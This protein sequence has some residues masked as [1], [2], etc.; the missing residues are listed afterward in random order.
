MEL[1]KKKRPYYGCISWR[2]SWPGGST[3]LDVRVYQ[4]EAEVIAFSSRHPMENLAIVFSQA[5]PDLLLKAITGQ[6]RPIYETR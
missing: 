1:C 6:M 4:T 2:R 5:E 3:D